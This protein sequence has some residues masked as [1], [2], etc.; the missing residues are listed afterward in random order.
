MER[1]L[2]ARISSAVD[3]RR[4]LGLPSA[5]TNAYRL[6]NSEGDRYMLNLPMEVGTMLNHQKK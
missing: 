4:S 1:L 6:V 5:N 3:L 2:E